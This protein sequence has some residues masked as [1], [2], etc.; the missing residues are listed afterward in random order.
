MQRSTEEG[1]GRSLATIRFFRLAENS[2]S[3]AGGL[4]SRMETRYFGGVSSEAVKHVGT[5]VE[6]GSFAGIRCYSG[7]VLE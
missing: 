1:R 2:H 3:K 6:A 7:C 5:I 4:L